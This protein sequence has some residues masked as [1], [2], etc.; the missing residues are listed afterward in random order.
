MSTSHGGPQQILL[1]VTRNPT[2]HSSFLPIRCR[3]GH[4]A[5]ADREKY[6]AVAERRRAQGIKIEL[7]WLSGTTASC[8]RGDRRGLSAG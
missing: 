8:I 7:R 2:L 5:A 3:A 6:G 4:S 1:W